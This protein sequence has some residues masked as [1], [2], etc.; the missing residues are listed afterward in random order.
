VDEIAIPVRLATSGYAMPDVCARHGMAATHSRP[1]TLVSRPPGWSY[2][3]L[4]A[5][6]LLFWIV[7][8]ALRRIVTVPAWPFCDGC[9]RRRTGLIV[10][11]T[12]VLVAGTAVL[13]GGA[14]L[15]GNDPRPPVAARFRGRWGP[16]A[17]SR[18]VATD[19]GQ[20]AGTRRCD[21]LPQRPVGTGAPTGRALRGPGAGRAGGGHEPADGAPAA[22][23]ARSR[24]PGFG[25]ARSCGPGFG[26]VRSRRA[27]S[28]RPGRAPYRAAGGSRLVT[29]RPGSG[30]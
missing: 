2:L 8:G 12:A 19:Q 23:G 15:V 27:G 30:W 28:R 18:T 24:R 1:T 20:R 5:G 9:R 10:A 25:V 16:P 22:A 6:L 11:G 26:A 4:P 3:L 7:C 17:A 13:V 29:G 21:G 14:M